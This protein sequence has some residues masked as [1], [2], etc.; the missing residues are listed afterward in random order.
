MEA[1]RELREA[2]P[3]EPRMVF[4]EWDAMPVETFLARGH[5]YLYRTSN[6]WRD[7]YPRVVGEALA[8]GLPVLT[9]PR[10][11]TKDRVQHG[12]TGFYCIDYDGFEY[13]LRLMDRKEEYRQDMGAAAKE[14]AKYHLDP[15]IWI[16]VLED[17]FY[18]S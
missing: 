15:R 13:A 2:F 7:Q 10:D 12:D 3:N 16:R 18:G 17:V 8:A 9:E 14:W 4:H 6:L 1:H 5:V 11:G